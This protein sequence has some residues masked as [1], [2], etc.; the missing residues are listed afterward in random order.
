MH[1]SENKKPGNPRQ[2]ARLFLTN[3][4]TKLSQ[5]SESSK[6]HWKKAFNP[7]YLGAYSLDPGEDRIVTIETAGQED[8]M[9][10]DGKTEPCLVLRL[11]NEKPMICNKTNAKTI[12]KVVG[13]NYLEDWRGK[14]I[15]IYVAK[16]KAFGELTDALR[17][18][19]MVPSLRKLSDADFSRMVDAIKAG[20]F[21][22]EDA[23]TR[24]ALTKAQSEQIKAL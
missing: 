23:A 11:A 7:N 20:R 3:H 13:S 18:R 22:K 14:R 15:Q 4:T 19:P 5:M 12:A 10:A 17:V 8:V 2:L 6:T 16:I 9:N 21:K 24:Y 1:L